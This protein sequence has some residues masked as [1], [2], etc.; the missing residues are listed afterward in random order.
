M[1]TTFIGPYGKDPSIAFLSEVTKGVGGLVPIRQTIVTVEDL[2][3][4]VM[5]YTEDDQARGALDADQA[6][7]LGETLRG[8]AD[9]LR[10]DAEVET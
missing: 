8:Y 5:H 6:E 3:L 7:M 2:G 10:D 9:S 1:S 4:L